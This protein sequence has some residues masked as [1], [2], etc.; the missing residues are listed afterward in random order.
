MGMSWGDAD[1]VKKRNTLIID[2]YR[3]ISHLVSLNA[4]VGPLFN[5]SSF[6]ILI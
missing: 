5:M 2:V 3:L 6:V 1:L 4:T